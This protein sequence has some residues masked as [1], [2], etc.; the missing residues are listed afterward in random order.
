MIKTA[1][2]TFGQF[3]RY[4]PDSMIFGS[5]Y[6]SA[7]SIQKEYLLTNDPLGYVEEYQYNALQRILALAETV[8]YYRSQNIR[9]DVDQFDQ[10]PLID[11]SIMRED[12]TR[13]LRT[14][15]GAVYGTTGGTSGKPFGFF[16]DRK[17]RGVEWF[18]MTENWARVGFDRKHSYRAVLR[19]HVLKSERLYE[20]NTLLRELYFTNYHLTDDYLSKVVQII[21]DK[22]VDFIHAYPSAAYRLAKY[23]LKNNI[24]IP[25]VKAFLCGSEDVYSEQRY[26]IEKQLGI[27]LYSWYGHSEK[28]ILAGECEYSNVYHA[29]PFYGYAELIDEDG[30]TITEP[31]V[32]GELVGTG[33]IN[34]KMPFIRYRTGDYA[35][36][37]GSQC[38]HCGRHGLIFSDVKGRWAGE[39][40]FYGDGSFVST[41]ALNMHSDVYENINGM[42][43]YQDT[44]G[45]LE[46]RIVPDIS[47]T[48]KDFNRIQKELIEKL[49]GEM[50]ISL[51]KVE[52][53]EYTKN[54][55]F[56]LLIQKLND[57][58]LL[59]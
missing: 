2:Y 54:R 10:V 11:K 4:L 33:F 37:V 42:Q 48:D 26:T 31:G 18:W 38:P 12:I 3:A 47:Y 58:N 5:T 29:N 53:L 40:V 46:V 41:T 7:Q 43:Y 32:R 25:T 8:E 9:L 28:L 16:I 50:I 23:L 15:R 57:E 14:K 24:K 39:K 36:Y 1:I 49:G 17:R 55:K 20:N 19:N 59:V 34:T 27:R 45:K 51:K 30:C 35:T 44:P 22:G 6:R 52:K 13:F 56:K 21:N